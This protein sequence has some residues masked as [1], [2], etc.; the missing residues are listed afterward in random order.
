M[1]ICVY[2]WLKFV[3]TLGIEKLVGTVIIRFRHENPGGPVQIAIVQR[4]GIHKTLRG[5]DAV[6][7]QHHDE[8]LGVDDRAGVEQF[9]APKLNHGWTQINTD[10]EIARRNCLEVPSEGLDPL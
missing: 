9:H 3:L 2:L 1:K 5:G 8:Y 10:Y 7:F 6:L 4:G